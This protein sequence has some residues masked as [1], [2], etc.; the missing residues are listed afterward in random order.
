MSKIATIVEK[1][2]HGKYQVSAKR[3]IF[4]VRH[5]TRELISSH[6]TRENRIYAR[7]VLQHASLS[8]DLYALLCSSA[9]F[10]SQ[11]VTLRR[12]YLRQFGKCSPLIIII[13][14]ITNT[15][16]CLEMHG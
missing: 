15:H 5:P 6:V 9:P 11:L 16:E 13:I 10:C 14:I 3:L 12:S 1:H 4:A 2:A 8:E 7:E